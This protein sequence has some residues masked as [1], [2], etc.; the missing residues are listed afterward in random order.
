VN[1]KEQ[2]GNHHK[3]IA[4]Y[5]NISDRKNLYYLKQ[6]KME[7]TNQP[8]RQKQFSDP[9]LGLPQVPHSLSYP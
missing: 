1:T 9:F 2:T 8:G 7:A 6:T 4:K 3:R 5:T